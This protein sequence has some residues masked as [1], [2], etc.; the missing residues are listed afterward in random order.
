MF[1]MSI[2]N[3]FTEKSHY[4]HAAKQIFHINLCYNYRKDSQISRTFFR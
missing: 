3:D 1:V 4:F 2:V